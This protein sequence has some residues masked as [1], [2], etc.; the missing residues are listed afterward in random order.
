MLS[1][2]RECKH[3][4]Q[5]LHLHTWLICS[6]AQLRVS[7]D[8]YHLWYLVFVFVPYFTIIAVCTILMISLI[9][10]V[11]RVKFR[12]RRSTLADRASMT[13][14]ESDTGSVRG[15]WCSEITAAVHKHLQAQSKML[16]CVCVSGC[17]AGIAGIHAVLH[18]TSIRLSQFVQ[19]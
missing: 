7:N 4:K 3:N 17:K 8:K 9:V 13:S 1:F 12:A 18:S 11:A 5:L 6:R 14:S 16:R 10:H 15:K 19:S 2:H